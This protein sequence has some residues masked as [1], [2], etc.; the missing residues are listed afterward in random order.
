MQ[1]DPKQSAVSMMCRLSMEF[2]NEFLS[3]SRDDGGGVID[4][5]DFPL[6]LFICGSC[7]SRLSRDLAL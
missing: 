2:A 4:T 5:R 6:L 1:E 7:I 3:S